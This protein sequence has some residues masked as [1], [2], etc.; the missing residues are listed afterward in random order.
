M[1]QISELKERY[2]KVAENE[3]IDEQELRNIEYALSL[4]LPDDF[5]KISHFFAGGCL[6]VVENYSFIQGKWDNIIDETKRLRE[7]VKLPSE[8]VVLAE[9]PE[10]L[11]VMDVRSKPSIIWCDS[12]DIYNL[13]TKLYTGSPDMWENYSDFFSELLADE[14]S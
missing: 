14:E 10:S 1:S 4:T 13:R 9:P 3:G 5:K 7:T 12:V 2:L 11:I 8:F 6:G